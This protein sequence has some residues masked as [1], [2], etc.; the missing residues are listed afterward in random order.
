MRFPINDDDAATGAGALTHT[1]P[2]CSSLLCSRPQ[3]ILHALMIL[4]LVG[5]AAAFLFYPLSD[6][7]V[8]N[9]P[10][11]AVI[12]EK[13]S[14][15]KAGQVAVLYAWEGGTFVIVCPPPHTH[16]YTRPRS[17]CTGHPQMKEAMK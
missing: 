3:L 10:T 2:R 5:G 14:R 6:Y 8:W 9:R 17:P 16:T 1:A 13:L 12:V 4:S 15:S 7:R 11:Q